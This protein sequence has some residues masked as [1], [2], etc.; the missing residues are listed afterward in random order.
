MTLD[1]KSPLP[2]SDGQGVRGRR[3]REGVRVL[4]WSSL[5]HCVCHYWRQR[6]SRQRLSLFLRKLHRVMYISARAMTTLP[7][8]RR[9]KLGSGFVLGSQV[10]SASYVS[11]KSLLANWG[12][13][14][15]YARLL[16]QSSR[17]VTVAARLAYHL[18]TIV[19]SHFYHHRH[20]SSIFQ[21]SLIRLASLWSMASQPSTCIS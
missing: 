4:R 2:P 14:L 3:S 20:Q 7:V 18:I 6:R 8:T 16:L 19:I 17:T 12:R 9:P 1:G 21:I 10:H 13:C 15:L 5:F 11:L